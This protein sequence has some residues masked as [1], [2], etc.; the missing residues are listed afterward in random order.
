[1]AF[2][3]DH[4]KAYIFYAI[5]FLYVFQ[6]KSQ[7]KLR[8]GTHAYYFLFNRFF[9]QVNNKSFFFHHPIPLIN[10]IYLE[11]NQW[12]NQ[13]LQNNFFNHG[14][15]RHQIQLRNNGDVT[16]PL[17]AVINHKL[18]VRYR[19]INTWN[20]FSGDLQ[21]SSSLCTIKNK[22]RQLYLSGLSMHLIA[23]H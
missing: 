23:Y 12:D 5:R 22:L 16:I 8:I 21:S 2:L 18:F 20:D 10:K 4:L 9:S 6:K 13:Y 17:Y 11:G 14:D 1:M 19:A 15:I 3:Q 7:N